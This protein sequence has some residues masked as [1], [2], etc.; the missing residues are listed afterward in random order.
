[1]STSRIAFKRISGSGV[2]LPVQPPATVCS[3][4]PDIV[5]KVA[6]EQMNVQFTQ[7]PFNYDRTIRMSVRHIVQSRPNIVVKFFWKT[8]STISPHISHCPVILG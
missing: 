5:E 8:F 1:L 2:E 6:V 3:S 7:P 4:W